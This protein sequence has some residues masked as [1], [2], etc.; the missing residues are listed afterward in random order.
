M[1]RK[2]GVTKRKRQDVENDDKEETSCC[3]NG[4]SDQVRGSASNSN[5]RS[6]F[7]PVRRVNFDSNAIN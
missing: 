7:V 4:I 1:P 3:G 5:Q 6:A 2:S